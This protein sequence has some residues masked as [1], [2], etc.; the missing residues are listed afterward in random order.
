[1]LKYKQNANG[2]TPC[3]VDV[4]QHCLGFELGCSQTGVFCGGEQ[5]RD[6][7]MG[8]SRRMGVFQ[9]RLER[10]TERKAKL[11]RTLQR[12]RERRK[13]EKKD[14]EKRDSVGLWR[15]IP[16]VNTSPLL[17]QSN[18]KTHMTL[19]TLLLD[20]SQFTDRSNTR[21]LTDC[22]QNVCLNRL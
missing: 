20:T 14:S 19:F 5:K 17:S 7:D 22:T 4:W 11:N 16:S 6:D 18:Y 1:M 12:E 3:D 21:P 10:V 2:V 9:K 15:C 8:Q 13:N